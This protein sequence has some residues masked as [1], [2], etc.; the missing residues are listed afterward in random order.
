M[1]AKENQ[2]SR[3]FYF[4]IKNKDSIV[5]QMMHPEIKPCYYSDLQESVIS[6]YFGMGN[7]LDR[8]GKHPCEEK[9]FDPMAVLKTFN[10]AIDVMPGM[11]LNN[12]DFISE[13]NFGFTV[14]DFYGLSSGSKL[15]GI[16]FSY[17]Y[18]ISGF[19]DYVRDYISKTH[20]VPGQGYAHY[21]NGAYDYQ[22][23]SFYIAK[24]A[25]KYFVFEGGYGKNFFGDGYRS[26]F[27][28]DAASSYP[29][30][31]ITTTI[32]KINM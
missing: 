12:P 27:L 10:P 25:G 14:S 19:P 15:P 3:E 1:P 30:F 7:R 32:W 20:V 24:N 11:D 13:N 16:S 2:F 26:L 23:L 8:Y 17:N 5:P 9:A 28:S 31:K 6:N 22:N 4:N 21:K 29:Y 18:S